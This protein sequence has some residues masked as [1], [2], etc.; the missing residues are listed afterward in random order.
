[1]TAPLAICCKVE[2]TCWLDWDISPVED[3]I[4]R[5]ADETS[6]AATTTLLPRVRRL[7]VML[8]KEAA[9]LLTSSAPTGWISTVRSPLLITDA[10][11]WSFFTGLIID[12]EMAT[13]SDVPTSTSTAK[14]ESKIRFAW[15]VTASIFLIGAA[16]KSWLS[17]LMENSARRKFP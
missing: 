11:S 16:T 12:L 6:V 3:A 17:F 4:C 7:A 8:L 5:E 14:I 10:A 13:E 1:M 2:E 15:D 9:S